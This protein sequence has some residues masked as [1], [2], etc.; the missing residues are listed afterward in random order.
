[1]ARCNIGNHGPCNACKNAITPT[2]RNHVH[3][4]R[5]GYS[6]QYD[7]ICGQ[8]WSTYALAAAKVIRAVGAAGLRADNAQQLRRAIA[9]WV[10][11]GV[12][13]PF[14]FASERAN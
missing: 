8:C 4:Y 1:M 13:V 10:I 11:I 6:S 5:D 7:L 2:E 9:D 12:E 3:V 14:T